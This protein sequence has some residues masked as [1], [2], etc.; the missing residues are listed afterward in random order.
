MGPRSLSTRLLASIS[1]LLI[2]FFG[3]TIA[4]L[5]FAFRR[6][7]EQS[8]PDRLDAQLLSLISA[9]EEDSSGGLEP[10]TEKTGDRMKNPGSGLYGEILRSDGYP[11]W[12]SG[13]LT[14]TGLDFAVDL[15]PGERRYRQHRRADGSPVRALSRSIAWQFD[16]GVMRT[17]VYS[18]AEDLQPN[19]S[20]L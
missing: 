5:D 4:A 9:S 15:P 20:Q 13:S 1:I 19:Y 11:S 17:F 2:V 3:I 14:G 10:A 8:M 12:R 6:V 16:N 7:T 18:A